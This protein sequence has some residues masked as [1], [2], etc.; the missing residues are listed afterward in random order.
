M[1]AVQT[2]QESTCIHTLMV[3]LCE[4][5]LPMRMPEVSGCLV[6]L[7][8]CAFTLRQSERLSATSGGSWRQTEERH[9]K[10]WGESPYSFLLLLHKS[11][12][13]WNVCL[14]VTVSCVQKLWPLHGH[15]FCWCVTWSF[16][17]CYYCCPQIH[18]LCT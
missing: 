5:H 17:N 10:S 15:I 11:V 12:L 7:R 14:L 2:N 13:C 16:S 6:C 3:M 18:A 9:W 4:L 8:R 1:S